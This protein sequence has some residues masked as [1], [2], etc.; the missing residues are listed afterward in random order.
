VSIPD[1]YFWS[2]F[3]SE[4]LNEK[5]ACETLGGISAP[6]LWRGVKSGRYPKPVKIGPRVARWRREELAACIEKLAAERAA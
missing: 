4:L 2:P 1:I 6:T 3:M 5:Q